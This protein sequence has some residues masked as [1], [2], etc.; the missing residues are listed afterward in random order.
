MKQLWHESKQT[1]SV[2]DLATNGEVFH[3]A[4]WFL[5][6]VYY[7]ICKFASSYEGQ[8]KSFHP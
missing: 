7:S 1:A 8:P 3:L 2:F 5:V 6:F 4:L